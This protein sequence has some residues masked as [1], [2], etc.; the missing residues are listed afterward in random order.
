MNK[1][2]LLIIISMISIF[3]MSCGNGFNPMLYYNRSSKTLE[4]NPEVDLGGGDEVI[5]PDKDPFVQG[6]WNK[7]D[8]KFDGS[9]IKNYFFT[10]SFDSKNV[11]TYKFMRDSSKSWAV[12]DS[13]K[14]EYT[15]DGTS[16]NN[17]AQG[18]KI[19]PANFYRYDGKN[20]LVAATSSYNQSERLKRFIFY[21]LQGHA[22]IVPLN[23][24]LIAVDTYSKLVFAYGKITKTETVQI[25]GQKYPVEF[26]PVEMYGDERKFYEYDPIG[27]M[28][29]DS[30][31][32]ELK[33]TLY[34]EY[35]DE[36]ARDAN[37][38]F[39]SIH[40]YARGIADEN[41]PGLSPY[42]VGGDEPFEPE[43]FINS[44]K[45]KFYGIRNEYTLYT[46]QFSEDGS[47]VTIKTED[48]YNGV[49]ENKT[50]QLTEVVSGY[51]AN[52]SGTT[53]IGVESF[54]K[55]RR[56]GIE[57]VALENYQDPGVSFKLRVRGRTYYA[58]DNSYYYVFSQDASTVTHY[59]GG[60]VEA[61]Y[62]F[63]SAKD[64]QT[65]EYQ[66]GFA[67]YW[68]LRVNDYQ[69]IKDGELSWSLGSSPFP[70]ATSALDYHKGYLIKNT[71]G[72]FLNDIKDRTYQ[73]RNGLILYTYEFSS[74]GR[75]LTYKET[76]WKGKKQ[77]VVKKYT[78]DDTSITESGAS[79]SY[80]GEI[81]E[82][83]IKD[84]KNTLYRGTSNTILGIYNYNDP[85]PSFLER[86]AGEIYEGSGFT[87]EFSDDGTSIKCSNGKTYTYTEQDANDRAIYNDGSFIFKYW[88][89]RL[90]SYDGKNDGVLY[91]SIGAGATP[92]GTQTS[93]VSSNPAYKK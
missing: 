31:T 62:T 72:N 56:D 15:Y 45:G 89:L 9:I 76:D 83:G 61:T 84:D 30:S 65:A 8:Y 24:Y 42:Y 79:Y 73:N 20:P 41:G 74:D 55:L 90:A 69:G 43:D 75:T 53:L 49:T 91:W 47:N 10:S 12:S 85:G 13:S 40:D 33:L 7:E 16:F 57:Y 80:N 35:K 25:N 38:Y 68:G 92:G 67:A 2:K 60:K 63:D 48:Y 81:I 39:P 87:Y 18:Y 28:T 29:Y 46:Y 14:S 22:V 36:M 26:A 32:Q 54:S 6:D 5:N 71:T 19:D 44:V 11:P 88:G 59:K 82:A 51:S 4:K 27:V 93:G 66:A 86:V 34:Q 58:S 17:L 52:Y 1:I 78:V 3:M 70:G 50:L 21:R 23:N 64:N 77:E 37:A